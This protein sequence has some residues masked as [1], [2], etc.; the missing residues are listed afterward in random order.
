MANLRNTVVTGSLRLASHGA[1]MVRTDANGTISTAAMTAGDLPSHNHDD[2]YYTES[3]INSLLS[4]KQDAATAI[5]TSNIGSQSVN[6]ANSAGTAGQVSGISVS[7]S[8]MQYL[9]N[10][11]DSTSLPYTC[12]I[13]V[14]GDANTYYPVHFIWGDQ[15]VWRRIVIKR[16]Y[17]EEAPWDPIGTGVHHGGLL[18]DWEGNFGGWGG[19]EYSDRLRVFNESYTNVCADMFI[20]THSMGYVF[21][22]RGGHALY[23]I[24]SDQ[25]IRGYHQTGTPDIAYNTSTLFYDHSNVGYRVYAPAPVTS[26]N[27]SRIDGL[28]TKKQSLFDGRYLQTLSVSGTNLS[29]SGGNSVTL[30]TGG[31]S[32]ST[33]DG[34]YVKKNTWDGNLYLHT[35][36]RIYGTI[37][38]DANN[39]GYFV[40]PSNESKLYRLNVGGSSHTHENNEAVIKFKNTVDQ[41]N[42]IVSESSSWNAWNQWIRYIGSYNTWRIGTYDE[43]QESGASVWRLAGRNRSSNGELNY[44]VAGPRGAWGSDDRVILYNPYA[45]Y[46]GGS[47]NGDGT[48][49]ALLPENKWWNSKYFSSNGDIYGTRFLDS[50]DG[51]Y[52]VDPNSNSYLS[53]LRVADASNGVS[54]SVGNG[55][56]HGVYTLDNARKYLVVAADYYPHMAIVASGSNNTTHGAVLSFVGSEG[57]S[58]RQWNLGI[59]NNNPFLFSI[60]YNRTTDPN[61]HYGVGDGWSGDDNNHARLSIDRDGNTKI[62]GMLY[63]NGTSGGI[64]TGSAVL[65]AGNYSS[66]ALPL[67]GGTLSGNLNAWS[68]IVSLNRINF[69]TTAGSQASDPYC[70]RWIDEN[71][72]RGAGLSWLEFQLN[73]DSNEE[74]RIYG[75]SCVGHGCGPIS[76]NLYHR[77]RADGYAWHAG[78]LQADGDMRAPIFYDSNDTT[79]YMDYNSTTSGVLRGNLIFNDYGAGVVG[80]YT[81]TRYQGVFAMGNAYKLP[82]DGTSTGN[83]YGIAW[84]HTNVGGQS[85]SGLDHQALFMMNGI[86]QTAIGTGI[87]TNGLITTTSHGTSANWNTAYGWGNHA[88]AGYQ[89]ASTAITTS[90]I[91]S[92]SVNYAGS[93]GNADTV[94]GYHESAFWR[95]G[96]DRT[97]GVL[98]FSGEGGNSGNAAHAYAIFQEGGD[99]SHP[100]PDLRIAFHTGIKLG[101]HSSYNG[102]RFYTDYD[103]SGQV[104][105]VNNGSDPLGGGNVYVNNSLQAGSSLRAPIF[106]DSD[107]TAYY[108]DPNSTTSAIFRGSVGLNNTSPINSNW[109]NASNTTQ[110]SIY[111]SNYGLINLRGD[112]GG[113]ARTFSMGVGDQ[114]FYMCY[115]NTAGRH[116]ITVNS[117][118][119]V[120]IAVDVRAPIF[121]DS[122]DTNYYLDPNSAGT[123]LRINGGIV[124]TAGNGA[125]LLKHENSEANAWIFRENAANWG[126]FWFNAGSQSGQTI[127]SYTTVGAE[128]FGMN[129]AVTGFN[130]N[131]AW[132][133]TDSSTRAAWMLSNYSGYLWTQGTQYS[134]TD[135]RAP[136]FYDSANTGYYGDF[137]STSRMNIIRADKVR[138]DTNGDMGSSGWWAHDPYGYGWGQPHGSFR[139]LEV[140]SSGNFSTEPAMFRIHQWGSGAAEFWKP[141]GTILYLRETPGGGSSWFTKFEVQGSLQSNNLLFPNGFQITQGGSNYGV[142]NSWVRLDGHYGFY[143]GTNS[144]HLYPNNN[145]YGAWKIS[146]E[147]NGW[148]G[149]HFGEGT[150]I[151][152]MMNEGEFGFHREGVGWVGRFTSGTGHFNISG[153]ATTATTATTANV[154]KKIQSDY[155]EWDFGWGSHTVTTP[156]SIS[157]WDNYTQGGAPSGYGTIVDMYGLSGHQQDQFY[158]YQGNILHR[159][160]WYGNNN[161]NGWYNVLTSNSH[162]YPSNMNQYVR[163]SDA[164]TFNGI[165]T[166]DWFRANGCTG[167]YFQSYGYGLRAPECEGNSYGNVAT[168]GT[169]RNGWSGY[170]IGSQF[171]IMGRVGTDLGLHDNNYGWGWYWHTGNRSLGIGESTTSSSYKLYVTGAIYATGDIVAFSDKRKKTDII[172]IEDALSKVKDMRGVFYTKIDEAHKGRQVGVIAQEMNEVLPEAVTYAADVDEYGVKYGNIVGVLIE[173]IKEQQKQIEELK[174]KLA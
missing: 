126:L 40:D 163:T 32:Q 14:D 31:I 107:N 67:S 130:P 27:S 46:D 61:P 8:Q 135:M 154:S 52:Y 120:S 85:K 140:S 150:G 171:V 170:G 123:A 25:P 172:T 95:N 116:N 50:N 41:H 34:L 161:W 143:S 49:H 15:D 80:T 111:G 165:Y 38:Y 79:Y 124:S 73:D 4:G 3:E 164:P 69:T 53:R 71:S 103:M 114:Q 16:G 58:F 72:A 17:S 110:L 91:G 13:Y 9:K 142:F 162:P 136:I 97:I 66:Y 173:A 54:L 22:L 35:D 127:G 169:G 94:D 87:W 112:N 148:R 122:N 44:I 104:M 70:I 76:D 24:S 115:D 166:N 118:G 37:F 51:N 102:I 5:T 117:S 157:I 141:Q 167:L 113:T 139:S 1:G 55:S 137:A 19:A 45:R 128:L 12:D 131:S 75:N 96:Q 60:G 77:F 88:S 98:R 147:R 89:A 20:Y 155:Q 121:Y 33:A 129:N 6:Y 159:Y 2:R 146:G 56:T 21:M 11:L 23:H 152:L 109:G 47:Y 29:I 62:R 82:I 86:T 151:T 133:G 78:T 125:V 30:P 74:I 26:I 153:N 7:S 93:A 119:H 105:S 43:A 108:L 39:D 63:V 160:G 48:H 144:A 28:R 145:S 59:S 106:Y 149:L 42:Y 100:Y 81:S 64:S 68:G 156:M 36:G 99:W 101:A 10:T 158:F 65:H 138:G 90:N 92:Q 174:A 132:S 18:L 168:Y 83:L 84:T 57:G 134:Q